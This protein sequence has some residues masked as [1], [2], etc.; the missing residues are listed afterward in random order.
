MVP[1][2]SLPSAFLTGQQ[3]LCFDLLPIHPGTLA[4]ISRSLGHR[5][6]IISLQPCQTT[7]FSIYSCKQVSVEF[8]LCAQPSS[9]PEDTDRPGPWPHWAQSLVVEAGDTEAN[10]EVNER[11]SASVIISHPKAQPLRVDPRPGLILSKT[12]TQKNWLLEPHRRPGL[13]TR[14]GQESSHRRKEPKSWCTFNI[15]SQNETPPFHTSVHAVPQTASPSLI[16]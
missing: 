11:T 7:G 13:A 12:P 9:S 14:W 3:T 15:V 16:P 10:E 5:G 4:P 8:L 1:D 2:P 6:G